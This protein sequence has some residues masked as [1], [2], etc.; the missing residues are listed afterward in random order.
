MSFFQLQKEKSTAICVQQQLAYVSVGREHCISL[1]T[2]PRW[3]LNFVLKPWWGKLFKIADMFAIWLHPST[4]GAPAHTTKLAQDWIGKDGK[5]EWPPYSPDLN[6]VDYH[7]WRAMLECG[8][9]FRPKLENTDEFK[10]VPQLTWYQHCHRTRPKPNWASRKVFGLV[11]MLVAWTL[12]TCAEI[13]YLSD[14]GIGNNSK[15]FFRMK[16]TSCC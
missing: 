15:C 4:D 10:K 8:K 6:P 14:F 3:M 2:R 11:R 16:I 9:S 7:V 1:Q 13:S 5:D 12:R